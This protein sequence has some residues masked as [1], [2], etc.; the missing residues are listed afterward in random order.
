MSLSDTGLKLPVEP[1][2]IASDPHRILRGPLLPTIVRIATPVLGLEALYTAY[3]LIDLFWVGR[4]GAAASAALT[5][6][7][8]AIW[9][10][11]GLAEAVGT[12]ILALVA[13][14][15]G[16]GDRARAGRAAAQ[17]IL[18][19]F[20]LGVI[21]AVGV[22][23]LAAPLFRLLGV[24]A[25]V[26]LLGGTYLGTLLIGAPALFLTVAA[27]S[28]WRASGDTMT[29][30][31]VIGASLLANVVLNPF[32]IFGL[33]PFPALGVA[34]TAWATIL[35][36]VMAV[37]VFAILAGR[38]A[39]R[40]PL[41]RG[42]LLHPNPRAMLHTVQIGIPRFLVSS[43]FS[44][45]YLALSSLVARFGTPALAVLG[46]ANR[47]ESIVYL[48][49]SAIGAASATLVG[50]NLGARQAAR[51]ARAAD[52]AAGL[53]MG[54]AFLPGLAML[55]VPSLLIRPFTA[56]PEVLE[57]SGPYLRIIGL[58]QLFMALEIVY[59][60]AFAGAGDTLP[61]MLVELPI[62]ISRIPLAWWIAV[63]LGFELI[64]VAWVI[65]ITCCVRGVWL[66]LWFRTGRWQHR[67]L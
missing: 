54:L 37:A 45:V 29:P 27:E 31:K 30:F 61:P 23:L 42:A 12:G 16:A 4:L 26:A 65:S 52:T 53:A 14:A 60:S 34:G 49:C 22:R 15:L 59:A 55:V 56:D 13:R 57:L 17:G 5:T 19:A 6:S 50:Q 44:G 18:V 7:F 1:D 25:E 8:F 66:A 10:V 41:E 24:P 47:I 62:S 11:G 36:W 32:L 67:R 9:M 51:A 20:A 38:A 28:I 21:V 39:T 2:L 3:H 63:P 64:G 58:S 40:F 46:L 48:G 43:L 33:G 35:A